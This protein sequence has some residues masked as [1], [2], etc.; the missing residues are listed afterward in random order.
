MKPRYRDAND[1]FLT[2]YNF[3]NTP[4]ARWYFDLAETRFTEYERKVM[5]SYYKEKHS[6]Q[7]VANF[8]SSTQWTVARTVR[9]CCDLITVLAREGPVIIAYDYVRI[10][11]RR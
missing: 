11:N 2:V 8:L 5:R 1:F 10:D 4:E 3:Q 9:R 6:T 7:E